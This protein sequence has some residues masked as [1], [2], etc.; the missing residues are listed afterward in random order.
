M[1]APLR[2]FC[3]LLLFILGRTTFV[4][5]THITGIDLVYECVSPQNNRYRFDL[6]LY[7]DCLGGQAGFDATITLF[8]FNG[9]NGNLFGTVDINRPFTTPEIIPA[10]WNRCTGRVYNLCVE[11]GL[12]STFVTLPPRRGGYDVMWSRCCRNNAVTNIQSAPPQNNSQGVTAFVH[13]PTTAD[14]VGCNS[15]PVFRQLPPL[16]LCVN[17]PFNFDHSAIDPDG[18][19]LVYVISNPYGGINTTGFGTSAINPV[20]NLG[21]PGGPPPYQNIIY[22]PGFTY[23]DPFGTGNFRIDINSGN[24]TLTP[25]S[26]GLFVFALSVLEYRNGVLLS[27]NKRDFQINVVQCQP[28]GTPPTITTNTTGN[29]NSTADT[30]YVQPEDTLCYTLNLTDPTTT[31]IVE[32][33]PISAAFG[34]GGTL[35]APYAT[36]TQVVGNP[37]TGQV[38]WEPSCDYAGQTIPLIVSGRDTNDCAGYNNTFDTTWVV[39]GGANPPT[40]DHTFVIGGGS[41]KTITV[42]TLEQVCYD[43]QAEDIDPRNGVVVT[44]S[45]GPF[46]SLG[47]NAS[48]T[49]NGANPA[50]GRVCWRPGCDDAGQTHLLILQA[51]DTNYCNFSTPV[52]DTVEVIV[53]PLPTLTVPPVIEFCAGTEVTLQAS[54][55]APGSFSWIPTA[56]L[57]DPNIANPSIFPQGTSP[58]IV[59]YRDARF[60]CPQQDTTLLQELPLPTVIVSADAA[61][62]SGDS[63][64][65]AA[66]GGINYT[67]TPDSSLSSGRINNPFA[68]PDDTTTYQVIVEGANGCFDSA[69]V[70]I[71]VNPLPIVDAGRDTVKCGD[72]PIQLGANG[73][74]SFQWSPSA[75]LDDSTMFN[76]FA[77][78][79]S[80]TTYFVAVT[81]TNG[82]VNTDS[83]FVRTFYAD[84]GPD[85]P[86]CVFDS[87]QLNASG[88]V[89]YLWDVDPA[90]INPNQPDPTVFPQATQDFFV[91]VTDTTGC[92]DRDTVRI[93]VNPLPVT[94]VTN[95]DP[96]VCSG[97][98]TIITATGGSIY[99]WTPANTL[100]DSTLA[101]PTAFPINNGPNIIDSV[102]YFVTVTDTNGCSSDDS[103][104]LEVRIRPE[105][106][107]SADT[108]VC[109]GD[110]VPIF[111]QGGFG[112]IDQFW[113][114]GGTLSDTTVTNPLA[115]PDS[116][117]YYF[118]TVIAT[119]GCDNTDSVF[120]Y[121]I[122]PD[123]GPDLEVCFQDSIQLA[124]SGGVAYEWKP[125]TGL[126]NPFVANPMAS[127]PATTTYT[128]IVTDS[129]GCVDSAEM[130]LT[131]LPQPP[132]VTGADTAICIGDTAQLSAGGGI[133][134]AWT[135]VETL[136]N[137]TIA[138]PVAWPDVTTLY[139]VVVGDT[140]GCFDT[141]SQEVTV[142]PLPI[143]EAGLDA[144]ICRNDSAQLQA[145]GGEQ[146]FWNP[147][148]GLS[149]SE[150]ADPK[151]SPSSTTE[152]TVL[153]IDINGC[154]NTDSVVVNVIQPPVGET[155]TPIDSICKFD[156]TQ[157]E[158]SGA[159]AYVWSTGESE[160]TITVEPRET[161]RYWVI[162]VGDEGCPGDTVFMDVIVLELPEAGFTPDPAEGFAPLTVNFQDQSRY[163]TLYQWDFGDGGISTEQSPTHVFQEPGMYAVTL[164]VDNFVGCPDSYTF[165]VIEVLGA[166]IFIPNAFSP[167]DDGQNDE[168]YI[169]GGGIQLVDFRVFNRWGREVYAASNPGFRWD[170]RFQ[171]TSVPEGVYVY[172]MMATTFGG[173]RIQR[174]GTI[175]VIR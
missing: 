95:P 9:D 64:Q 105:I 42:N 106:T 74:V 89:A 93:T 123:A 79:D 128:V 129:V 73:G 135:P 39:V 72:I 80:S 92:T 150:I 137:D 159:L 68:R 34:I 57:S 115:F 130:V 118:A 66:L 131:V 152:Y 11:F 168:F 158:I 38:C 50:T 35:P 63:I 77:N 154:E 81:D 108:F 165:E 170:G 122:D 54:A 67:W 31:D 160:P 96:Y 111:V 156:N 124:A 44:P 120:V 65:L 12:Y 46:L 82:C 116:S 88:G 175:T 30:I 153:G 173:E 117:T 169:Q 26:Q 145:T 139:N 155:S 76:P 3:C 125:T 29:P 112:V 174:Q 21:N 20:I 13:V 91:T 163:S 24:L 59:T 147:A 40:I 133:S 7:R 17:N 107:V 48:F 144:T 25:T 114:P 151:A 87:L 83:V 161:T 119:W 102:W 171:G 141:V 36:L 127:P 113:T 22:L 78:P 146:Y 104:G 10:D 172:R 138:N 85:V 109:P 52:F 19:S 110:T 136:S 51:L 157:L 166:R 61:I 55:T 98:P 56:G 84:A 6:T 97:G 1:K 90:L 28:Q 69:E 75:G 45:Q 132:A 33:T 60:N 2:L 126:S 27:E 134:Y 103:I 164:T 23:L 100:N 16:F 121:V 167:N 99:S 53:R 47:G 58:Y 4:S 37:T 101:A 18:D 14:V 71:T 5:A 148:T 149:N 140:N 70:T 142:N 94:T 41:Q 162:P 43:F 62:C 49:S 143:I 32:L 15:S 8:I 86:L